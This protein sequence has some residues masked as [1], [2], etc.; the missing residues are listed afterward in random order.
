MCNTCF[1][2]SVINQQHKLHLHLHLHHFCSLFFFV[3]EQ[4][5]KTHVGGL[6]GACGG[7]G[8]GGEFGESG[9]GGDDELPFPLGA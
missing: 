7:S 3:A 8:G 9:G 6:S 4:V 1:M 5:K 2:H